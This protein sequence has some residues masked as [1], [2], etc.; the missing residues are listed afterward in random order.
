MNMVIGRISF[1]GRLGFIQGA[2]TML[3]MGLVG[4][5]IGVEGPS[6]I[7]GSLGGHRLVGGCKEGL[8]EFPDC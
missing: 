2:L 4:L 8:P 1:T 6:R 3:Q 5:R 7:S